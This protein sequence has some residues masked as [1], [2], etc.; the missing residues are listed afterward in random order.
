MKIEHNNKTNKQKTKQYLNTNKYVRA[1]FNTNKHDIIKWK[2]L[3]YEH[4]I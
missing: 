4:N 3:K 1:D 2:Y